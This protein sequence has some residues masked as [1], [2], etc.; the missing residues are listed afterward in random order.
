LASGG[1]HLGFHGSGSAI[2]WHDRVAAD[3]LARLFLEA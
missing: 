2:P 1:G 3:W